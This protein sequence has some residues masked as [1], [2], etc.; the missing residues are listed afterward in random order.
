MAA[1]VLLKKTLSIKEWMAAATCE[2]KKHCTLKKL[3]PVTKR[4]NL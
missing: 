1:S 2:V 3:F 4:S